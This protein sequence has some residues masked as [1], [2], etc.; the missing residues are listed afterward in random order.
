MRNKKKITL[1]VELVFEDGISPGDFEEITNN[2]HYA[3]T[4]AC[5]RGVMTPENSETYTKKVKVTLDGVVT[6]SGSSDNSFEPVTK[7]L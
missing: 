1:T 3:I 2:V 5:N 4:D 7:N 6:I